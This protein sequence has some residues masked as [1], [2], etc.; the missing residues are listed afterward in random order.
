M[1]SSSHIL[2][3]LTMLL[4]VPLVA[5][6]AAAGVQWKTD[7]T[8]HETLLKQFPDK[9]EAISA[10]TISSF[11]QNPDVRSDKDL[12]SVCEQDDY[13][14]MMKSGAIL[15]ACVGILMLVAIKLAG[16]IARKRRTVLLLLFAPG[17]HLT[18]LV[19]TCLIILHAVLGIAAIYYGE[20]AL[21]GRIHIG[22]MI[23]LGLGA[24]VGVFSLIRAQLAAVRKAK[25]TAIGKQLQRQQYARLWNFVDALADGMGAQ[26]PQSVIAGLEPNFY[27]TEADV[28]CV[29]GT[30]HGRTMY[31][32]LPLCRIL[33]VDEFKAVIG[34]ELGHYKGLD[35]KFSKRFYPIYRGATQAVVNLAS[36]FTER[37]A[38]NIVLLPAFAMLSFFL[39]SFSVAENEISRDRELAADK[40]ASKAVSARSIAT[41]LVKIHAFSAVWPV[42]RNHMKEVLESGK[43]VINA[44]ALFGVI[45]SQ[46]PESD[47]FKEVS[48][49]GPP[50]PT[51]THPPLSA[52]LENLNF[53]LADLT[54]DAANTSPQ[55]PAID[56][57]DAAEIL[58]EELSDIEQTLMM[59]SGKA[60]PRLEPQTAAVTP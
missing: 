23:G 24:I 33:S 19:M 43:M 38:G 34:H 12:G 3:I 39:D 25:T 41:S 13:L 44:S 11:C 7:S 50:H 17:L 46:I 35:T 8:L 48:Q 22:V 55:P 14:A 15:A 54:S 57:V 27:V 4:A 53:T 37:G 36:G 51:D 47:S 20:S 16:T 60:R 32:S 6:V 21:I 1:K 29:D 59:R 30:L 56:L 9:A 18:L 49:E 45:V 52:R 26:R 58:E 10:M 42:V 28:T 31:I 40:E 2:L 5:Y